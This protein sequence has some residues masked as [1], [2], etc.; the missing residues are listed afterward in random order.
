VPAGAD[1]FALQ[2]LNPGKLY[3]E[4]QHRSIPEFEQEQQLVLQTEAEPTAAV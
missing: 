2:A 1:C 3:G 4:M